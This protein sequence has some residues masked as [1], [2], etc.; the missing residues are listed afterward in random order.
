[1]V[2]VCRI[3]KSKK[4]RFCKEL[5]RWWEVNKRDYSWRRTED[6]YG[7]LIAEMMLRKTTASQVSRLY[8]DFLKEY[9]NAV[10]LSRANIK[11][12]SKLLKPLGMEHDR[13]RLFIKMSKRIV[14]GRNGE[15][16][17]S[18]G[19]LLE[20][21][22]VG[23]YTANAVLAISH[24]VNVPMLDSNFIRVLSRVFGFRSAK[25]RLRTDPKLW[26]FAQSLMPIDIN[27]KTFNFAVLDF[28]A[29]V[30][31]ARKP[32]CYKCPIEFLCTFAQV[33]AGE[34]E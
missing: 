34:P 3:A 20:L 21:P 7:I 11:D 28:A 14:D 15:V 22:G 17:S 30:C 4:N 24:G 16:P 26:E 33:N 12:V 25:K 5:V 31:K 10:A 23:T 9:P 29:K 27:A 18:I 32:L 19:E 2:A 13:A 8:D 1:M 6:P